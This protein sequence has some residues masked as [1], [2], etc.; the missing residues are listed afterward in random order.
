VSIW[1]LEIP[2]VDHTGGMTAGI[3]AGMIGRRFNAACPATQASMCKIALNKA[4][5][6]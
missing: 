6:K 1:E 4:Q 2:N 5:N 3:V